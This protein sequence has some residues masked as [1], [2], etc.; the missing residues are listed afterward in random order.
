MYDWANSAFAATIMAAVLPSFYSSVAGANLEKTIASS[1]WGYTNTIAMLI[2]AFSAP[3]LGAI[4]DYLGRKKVFLSWF[5]CIGVLATALMVLISKGDWLLASTLYI[6]GR[7]GF[8]GANIFYNSLLPHIVDKDRIDRV[9]ALGYAYGYLGGGLLLTINLL[10]IMKPALF[11][12]FSSEWG[13][14]LSFI[15][16]AVWWALF[17]FPLLSNVPEPKMLEGQGGRV[18][19]QESL[20][21]IGNPIKTG[22]SRLRS[23][24]REIKQYRELVKFLLAYWLYNDGIGTII[25]MAVIFGAEI[26][27]G[28]SHL[29]S[30]ILLVQFVAIP[31]SLIFGRLAERIGAKNSILI[32]LFTYGLITV[33]GYFMTEAIHFWVLAFMVAT[34]Q[35]GAQALSRSMYSSMLP[36]E[37]SAEFFGFYD[38]SS[39]FAGII[40]PAVFGIVGQITGSSRYGILALILFFAGGGL[41]LMNVKEEKAFS[42]Q[43]PGK[44]NSF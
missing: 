7:I 1:Y 41:L 42:G 29:I 22:F 13:V 16:V 40:G 44:H 4:A 6:F 17:S 38:V 37:K 19:N 9:S 8:A 28:Q 2:I 36:K 32:A 15:T 10:M 33:L 5:V 12:I 35:G 20:K 34:V 39:K 27:I 23:T 24:L 3:I 14:R 25:I 26:G 31:F 30:A 11:G 18:K 43:R 21:K